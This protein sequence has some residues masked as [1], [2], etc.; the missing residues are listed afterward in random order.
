MNR[1][2]KR[3][4]FSNHYINAGLVIE[5]VILLALMYIPFLSEFSIRA[6]FLD[7]GFT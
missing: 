2:L 7:Y 5:V 3:K 1:S 6:D 4:L